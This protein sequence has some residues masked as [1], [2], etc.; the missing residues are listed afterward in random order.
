MLYSILC[1]HMYKHQKIMIYVYIYIYI[2]VGDVGCI[3][4]NVGLDFRKIGS[5]AHWDL[6]AFATWWQQNLGT[7][8][9]CIVLLDRLRSPCW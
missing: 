5:C 4:C 6:K 9:C 1:A 7:F 3:C 8:V 2:L